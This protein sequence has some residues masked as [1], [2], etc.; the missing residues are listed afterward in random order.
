V[1]FIVK[2]TAQVLVTVV[3][4]EVLVVVELVVVVEEVVELVVFVEVVDVLDEVVKVEV[5][6]GEMFEVVEDELAWTA[7]TNQIA[8]SP[9]L[10]IQ[11]PVGTWV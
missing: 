10:S 6:V 11:L 2:V 3:R 7:S 1:L 5:D 8:D 9:G 4:I